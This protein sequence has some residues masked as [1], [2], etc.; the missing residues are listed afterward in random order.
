M[1]KN[2]GFTLLAIYLIIVGLIGVANI[3]L[4]ALSIL[5]PIFAIAAGVCIL[6]GK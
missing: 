1:K 6:I 3:S 5:V 4:G 2:I